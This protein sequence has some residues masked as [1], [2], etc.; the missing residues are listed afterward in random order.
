MIW[1]VGVLPFTST[2]LGGLAAFR[3]QH[4]LHAIMALAAGVLVATALIDLIPESIELIGGETA[5]ILTGLAAIVG[6]LIYAAVE[7]FI[8]EGS[9]EHGH[10]PSLEPMFDFTHPTHG[11]LILDPATGA[12]ARH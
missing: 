2:L 11:R 9:Y 12:P 4:R 6:Y 5:P 3:L 10:D 7:A 1:L 8:H